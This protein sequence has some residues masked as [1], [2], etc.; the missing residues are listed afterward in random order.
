MALNGLV[1]PQHLCESIYVPHHIQVSLERLPCW[2]FSASANANQN[3][4]AD[5]HPQLKGHGPSRDTLS[6]PTLNWSDPGLPGLPSMA[7]VTLVS[8]SFLTL[9]HTSMKNFSC[10]HTLILLPP[11][12]KLFSPSSPFHFHV[13]FV[14]VHRWIWVSCQSPG[15]KSREQGCSSVVMPW[16][17]QQTLPAELSSSPPGK[18]TILQVPLSLM[19]YHG[20]TLMQMCGDNHCCS[21]LCNGRV[22]SRR[23]LWG[24]TSLTLFQCSYPQ[25]SPSIVGSDSVASLEPSPPLH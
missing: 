12:L 1:S 10:F 5:A 3:V 21:Y 15:V 4:F 8:F 25:C 7:F 19:R 23:C 18:W 11:P 9:S 22:T 6:G 24:G 17:K 13:S 16:R 20:S 14:C 2:L